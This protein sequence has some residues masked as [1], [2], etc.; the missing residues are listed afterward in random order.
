[1]SVHT[2]THNVDIKNP[3]GNSFFHRLPIV[4]APT[5]QPSFSDAI[6]GSRFFEPVEDIAQIF[7]AFDLSAL[8]S[9]ANGGDHFT[10]R[11]VAQLDAFETTIRW[12]LSVIDGVDEIHKADV[13][14]TACW[15][16]VLLWKAAQ[17]AAQDFSDS[18]PPLLSPLYLINAAEEMVFPLE[19]LPS[20]ALEAHGIGFVRLPTQTPVPS[21]ATLCE[22][23]AH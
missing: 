15:V 9:T 20:T 18:N 2:H 16:R 1:M 10:P 7:M 5:S 11:G 8:C 12:I 22:D 6:L 14:V 23:L 4:L 17:S 13:L 21:G 19:N 3:R